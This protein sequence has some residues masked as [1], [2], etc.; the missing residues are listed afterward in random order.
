MNVG[1]LI[2]RLEWYAWHYGTDAEVR[3]V[4]DPVLP[5]EYS[6]L[7]VASGY[8]VNSYACREGEYNGDVKDDDMVLL[9]AGDFEALAS[10]CAWGATAQL[11]EGWKD[12]QP[13]DTENEG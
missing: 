9:I 11:E 8:Q 3:L 12:P 6:V 4:V 7:G 2:E 5:K 13:T 1:Q 10:R